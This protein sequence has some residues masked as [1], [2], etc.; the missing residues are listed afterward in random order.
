LEVDG[1]AD[2]EVQNDGILDDE[3]LGE[4]DSADDEEPEDLLDL[5]EDTVPVY[6]EELEDD[7]ILELEANEETHDQ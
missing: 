3:N 1:S 7:G 5:P 2:E 6:D 4:D